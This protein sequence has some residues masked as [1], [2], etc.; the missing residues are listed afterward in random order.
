M[1]V[2]KSFFDVKLEIVNTVVPLFAPD[3]ESLVGKV[4]TLDL[5]K[6]LKGKSCE[7]KFMVKKQDNALIGEIF[8]FMLYPSYVRRL[9]GHDVSIVEDSFVAKAQDCAL[10]V[11]PFLVTRRKVHRSVRKA[12]RNEAKAFIEKKFSEKT[13]SKIFHTVLAGILQRQLM[14]RLKKI[15]PLAVC[16]L[17]VVKVEKI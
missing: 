3:P 6:F 5:T 7:A 17:R 1:P 2:K 8:S 10:R 16:E 15:Y 9:I 11:K 4:V 12:L 13:R 14:K